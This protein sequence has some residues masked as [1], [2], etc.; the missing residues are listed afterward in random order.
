[1]FK[2]QKNVFWEAL[3]VAILIFGIGI[4]AGFVLENWR[5]G[6]IDL[7][8][9]KAELDL[10]D[11]RIQNDIFSFGEFNCE[12]AITENLKFADKIFEEGKILDRYERASRLS[13][14]IKVQH[15]KYDLLRTLLLM[16]SKIIKKECNTT[17][18]EV[19][20]FYSYDNEDVDIKA[21]QG[22]FSRSLVELKE[23]KGSEV[24]LIPIAA[25][26]GASS[27]SLLLDEYGISEADLPIVLINREIKINEIKSVDELESILNK[28]I[29]VDLGVIRL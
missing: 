11:I 22:V 23:R 13:E 21:K 18:I 7:L 1:M 27:I 3:L 2:S 16:N 26:I 25:D 28:E 9:Q 20:Y 17:Y 14:N 29:Q 15:M 5:T 12:K 19:V 10:L 4:L 24:L 6:S 8:S